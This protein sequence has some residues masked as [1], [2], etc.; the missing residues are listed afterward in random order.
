MTFW[1]GQGFAEVQIRKK[2]EIQL[3]NRLE[4]FNKIL[5]AH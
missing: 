1:I 3:L 5:Q 2:S 4:S